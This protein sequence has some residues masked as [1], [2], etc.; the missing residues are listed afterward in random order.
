LF[1]PFVASF[2]LAARVL[3]FHS[4]QESGIPMKQLSFYYDLFSLL[5]LSTIGFLVLEPE[6]LAGFRVLAIFFS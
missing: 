1:F 6:T 3:L 2:C 5:L 4:A